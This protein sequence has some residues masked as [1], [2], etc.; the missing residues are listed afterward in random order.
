[1]AA[2]PQHPTLQPGNPLTNVQDRVLGPHHLEAEDHRHR[3]I[4]VDTPPEIEK[5]DLVLNL[6]VDTER[7]ALFQTPKQETSAKRTPPPARRTWD[8]T[9]YPLANSPNTVL[10]RGW[11]W[12]LATM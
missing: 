3:I 11:R 5:T 12:G 8:Q 6:V 9:A 4:A 7:K 1:V 2:E 10:N